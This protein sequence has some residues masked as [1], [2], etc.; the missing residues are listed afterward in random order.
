MH[1]FTK[2]VVMYAHEVVLHNGVRETNKFHQVVVLDNI[3]QRLLRKL[4]TN[5]L[6]AK[7]TKKKQAYWESWAL[8]A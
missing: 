2:S 4:F 1:C 5:V 7:V 8:E 3:I 6:L